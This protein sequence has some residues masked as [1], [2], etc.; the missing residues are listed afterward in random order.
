LITMFARKRA[1]AVE[2]LSLDQA[3]WLASS[4]A[5]V[6]RVAFDANLFAQRCPPPVTVDSFN[7]I[8]SELGLSYEWST[9]SLETVLSRRLPVAVVL[10]KADVNS[11]ENN[12]TSISETI[13]EGP[14]QD[15]ALILN[16][17]EDSVWML[18]RGAQQP[19]S[20]TIEELG[21][22]YQRQS[23]ALWPTGAAAA[24]PDSIDARPARFSLRWFIP[25]LAKHKPVWRDV[26]IASLVLQLMGLATP[27]FTQVVIDKVVVHRTNSTLIAIG[28]GLVVFLL[29][30]TLLTWVRQYLI[31]HTGQRIDAVLG[32]RVFDHLFRL[33][34]FTFSTDPQA[35]L[36]PV[37]RVSKRSATSLHRLASP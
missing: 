15:F 18:E 30:T 23:V 3:L 5:M 16:A 8:V 24:D 31:L 19:V 9:S 29:F 7:S 12:A 6:H 20:I 1:D 33:P 27:L 26:L 37:C 25:E 4:F 10:S 22:R 14:R 17:N 2:S 34:P 35:L 21:K 32:S 13:S 36:P 28:V 11:G